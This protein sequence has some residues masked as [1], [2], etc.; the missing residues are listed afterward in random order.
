MSTFD[1]NYS[2]LTRALYSCP[3]KIR[4]VVL[5]VLQFVNKEGEEREEREEGFTIEDGL[6]VELFSSYLGLALHHVKLYE[7]IRKNEAKSSV[8]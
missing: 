6:Q 5:A 2:V 1:L 4:G 7:K 3:I 8:C